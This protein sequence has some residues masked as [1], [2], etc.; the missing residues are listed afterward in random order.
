MYSEL[1]GPQPPSNA[2][3]RQIKRIHTHREFQGRNRHPSTRSPCSRNTT[4]ADG[5]HLAA[6]A[7]AQPIYRQQH[8]GEG[9]LSS[10]QHPPASYAAAEERGRSRKQRRT[11]GSSATSRRMPVKE[12]AKD[13]GNR[14][15]TPRSAV[16][17]GSNK[18]CSR[19]LSRAQVPI[20]TASKCPRALLQGGESAEKES[21]GSSR[22]LRVSR[23]S[24]KRDRGSI[25]AKSKAEG[26]K[27]SR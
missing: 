24:E 22:V 8:P 15:R 23:R 16:G 18:L 26:R 12:Q 4:A 27:G 21:R 9:P 11:A 19:R 17:R 13:Q 20:W 2:G 3:R 6:H 14:R 7:T 25:E 5:R 1:L 10:S